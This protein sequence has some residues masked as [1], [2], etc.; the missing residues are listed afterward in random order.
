VGRRGVCFWN[1]VRCRYRRRRVVGGVM[2]VA[3]ACCCCGG[4]EEDTRRDSKSTIIDNATACRKGLK[5]KIPNVVETTP[6][7]QRITIATMLLSEDDKN[8]DE[9]PVHANNTNERM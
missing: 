2:M 5:S 7:P 1:L 3:R 4:E 8:H 9:T 6:N